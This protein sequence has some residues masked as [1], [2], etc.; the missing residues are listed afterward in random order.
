MSEWDQECDVLVVGSGA[1]GMTAAYTAGREGLDV[2]LAEST[3]RFGGMT[4]YSGGGMWMPCNAVL[5]RAGD[6]DTMDSARAYY[7][8]VVGT[9]TPRAVQDAFL[10]T[11]APLIDYLEEDPHFAFIVLPWPDYYGKAP[12]ARAEGR[13]IMPAILPA[14]ELGP[15]RDVMRANLPVERR[16]HAPQPELVGGQALIGRFLIAVSAMPNVDLRRETALDSLVR[17]GSRVTGAVLHTPAGPVRIKARAGVILAA[18]GF[19][20]NQTMRDAHGVPGDAA[21]SMAPPGNTGAA[22][23]AGIA[24]G[25]DVDLM[26]QGWWSPGLMQ[27][28]GT[29]SFTLGFGGGIFVDDAGQRFTNESAPYDRAGREIIARLRDGRL[30]LPFW[31]VYDDRE[32]GLPPIHYPNLPLADP[33]DYRA[34][35]LWRSAPTLAGLAEAIGVPADALEASVAR[36]NAQCEARHDA[37]FH[38][39]EEAYELLV[40]NGDTPFHPI[41]KAPFHAAAFGL[42]DLGTKGGLR[43]DEHAR[44]IDTSGAVLEGLYAAG[45][46]MAAAS[47]ET[48]PG[49]GNPVGSSMVFAFIAARHARGRAAPGQ[50]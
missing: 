16:G 27:P 30:T 37:D 43:T 22:I 1:G 2:V 25:A 40:N 41:V 20:R 36:F 5:R 48:Y 39:G 29:A 44:V 12:H 47:G 34:A 10:D 7:R 42:S 13:H 19:E 17:E 28:D 38:R 35:G 24:I 23:A 14:A 15:L 33:A 50:A 18:G 32:G 6:D 11:G 8:A 9:R 45:N 3:D 4:A 21:G 46:T 49:G 31:F 26:D